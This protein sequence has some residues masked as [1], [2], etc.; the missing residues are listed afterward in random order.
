MF[1]LGQ[2]AFSAV[3]GAAAALAT[4]LIYQRLTK[5]SRSS[6][7][8]V[9]LALVV[10]LSILVWRAGANTPGLNEDPITFVS[11][12]DLL[13]PAVTY[14]F[15][16]VYR[17]LAGPTGSGWPRVRALLAIASLIVNIVTI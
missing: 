10:G 15:L 9:A 1:A 5:D 8:P 6:G 17:G 14:I 3:V 13:C 16:G 11:P 2:I 7:S 4:I 12:N